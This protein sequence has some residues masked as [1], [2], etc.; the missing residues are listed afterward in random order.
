MNA[1][2]PAKECHYLPQL[3]GELLCAVC[4]DEKRLEAVPAIPTFDKEQ[5]F[6]RD[7]AIGEIQ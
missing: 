2:Y 5:V 4:A 3:G 7:A 1:I 6:E